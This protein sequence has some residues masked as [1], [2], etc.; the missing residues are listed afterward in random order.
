MVA[1][2]I[3]VSFSVKLMTFDFQSFTCVSLAFKSYDMLTLNLSNTISRLFFCN[4]TYV[5]VTFP[6]R[7][8]MFPCLLKT[9]LKVNL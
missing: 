6:W 3:R 9:A 1:G 7:G 8:S 4:L 5:A 2:D